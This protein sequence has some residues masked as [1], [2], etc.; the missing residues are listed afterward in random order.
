MI[1]YLLLVF[2]RETEQSVTSLENTLREEAFQNQHEDSYTVASID[3]PK[4]QE[5]II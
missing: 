4:N 1:E 3:I 5:S 2:L